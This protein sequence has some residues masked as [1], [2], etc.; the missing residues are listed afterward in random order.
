EIS[1][2]SKVKKGREAEQMLEGCAA[3]I[4]R[5]KDT[6]HGFD[7]QP[8][9]FG[10]TASAV[11]AE[12]E[13]S[14]EKSGGLG[15]EA[16]SEAAVD[17]GLERLETASVSEA[18]NPAAGGN[19]SGAGRE[20]DDK[21]KAKPKTRDVGRFRVSSFEMQRRAVNSITNEANIALQSSAEALEQHE[22]KKDQFGHFIAIVKVRRAL[23]DALTNKSSE[24][25]K[26]HVE[27]LNAKA[28][29]L[30]PVPRAMLVK[31]HV[32]EQLQD[33]LEQIM[34]KETKEEIEKLCSRLADQCTIHVQLRNSL[35]NS[36]RDLE[37]AIRADVKKQ[38][39]VSS[40]SVPF[41]ISSVAE[42]DKLVKESPTLRC[43][44]TNFGHQFPGTQLCKVT[45]RAQCP[46]K[47]DEATAALLKVMLEATP[48]KKPD[49]V[50]KDAAY[51]ELEGMAF[52]ASLFGFTSEMSYVG[53]EE[54]GLGQL[55]YVLQGSRR[56]IT[57]SP[58]AVQE[59]LG[60]KG[61][62]PTTAQ[63]MINF[64]KF[65]DLSKQTDCSF[66]Y[67]GVQNAGSLMYIPPGWLLA[68]EVQNGEKVVGLRVGI[69]PDGAGDAANACRND[70]KAFVDLIPDGHAYEKL[71]KLAEKCISQEA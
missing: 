1:H 15:W 41:V 39:R 71:A 38:E 69:L 63:D 54:R 64:W 46:A 24:D 60:G 44:L 12:L 13:S 16:S 56:V 49:A 57:A 26:R 70:F 2:G 21:S 53:F 18:G 62:A 42:I 47:K 51:K 17:L 3:M 48:F 30:Q 67:A 61:D 43:M 65:I 7:M 6:A 36:T 58:R 28:L 23:F 45:G 14:P 37:N 20:Q 29:S 11:E 10:K 22:S 66:M 55:R 52:Q 19:A 59:R 9:N 5:A 8:F 27:D 33:S 50:L 31:T 40:G 35:R 68:E 25:F 34:Q 32:L 4:R